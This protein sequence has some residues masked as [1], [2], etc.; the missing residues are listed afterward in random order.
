MIDQH[1]YAGVSPRAAHVVFVV[2]GASPQL[3]QDWSRVATR[4]GG[5]NNVFTHTGHLIP[6]A[7]NEGSSFETE[8][9]HIFSIESELPL[10]LAEIFAMLLGKTIQA[11][12]TL[13]I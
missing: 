7:G 2:G 4:V 5:R 12:M 9:A 10:M 6:F 13:Q 3:N 11:S 1:A 8:V